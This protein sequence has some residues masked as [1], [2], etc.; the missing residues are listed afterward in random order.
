MALLDPGDRVLL[1][2]PYWTSYPEQI[3]LADA[4]PVPVPAA[5]ARGYKLEAAQ[6]DEA[7][8]GNA[9]AVI[10][11]YPCNP[12]GACPSRAELE[13]IAAACVRQG[14]WIIADEIY[15]K[16]LYDGRAFTSIAQIA[17]E[18]ARRTVIVDGVSK[19]YSMTGWRIGFAA[20]PRE[21]IDGMAK[22][23]SH[24]TSNATSISQW[25]SVEA[26]GM[27]D[28]ELAPRTGELERRRD[29]LVRGLRELPGIACPTPEG[30]F[31][32]F[33]DVS[34]CFAGELASGQAFARYLLERA[35][36]AVVPGEAFGSARHV[37]LSYAVSIERLREGVARIAEAV[38]ALRR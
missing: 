14:L 6:I 24:S 3:R 19:T 20:G 17:P 27:S 36:V 32:A 31:Y 37:R 34:G 25:A 7:A 28:D 2:T 38:H 35:R 16:L 23:Q 10:L 12:T 33:P 1:P 4:V 22:L 13:P 11:N 26:L 21:I 8:G 18:V 5:A 9:K 15:G 29:E 30:A